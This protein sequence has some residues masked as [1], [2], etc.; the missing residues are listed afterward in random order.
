MEYGSGAV[1]AVPAH[2][3]RDYEF[4]KKYHLPIKQVI[5]PAIGSTGIITQAAFTDDGIL[6]NSEQFDGLTSEQAMQKIIA[7]IN[8]QRQRQITN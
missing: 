4:A 3:Q 7:R 6:I 5:K 8:A 2:D 1:M